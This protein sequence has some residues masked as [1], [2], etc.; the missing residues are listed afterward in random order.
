MAMSRR[1]FLAQVTPYATM[2]ARLTPSILYTE[3]EVEMALK[4]VGDLT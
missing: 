4:A 2:H 1:G 3:E